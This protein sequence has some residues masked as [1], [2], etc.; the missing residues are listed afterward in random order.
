MGAEPGVSEFITGLAFGLALANSL[1]VTRPDV[2]RGMHAAF[3][4]AGVDVIETASFGSFS[5]PLNEYGIGVRA[6]QFCAHPLTRRLTAV[7]VAR[8][9]PLGDRPVGR[10]ERHDAAPVPGASVTTVL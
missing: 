2:I 7:V 9:P 10:V 8:E 3:L 1:V 4:E 6:G 5:V